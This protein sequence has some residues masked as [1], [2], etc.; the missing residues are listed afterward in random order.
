MATTP[1]IDT[2][3]VDAWLAS[4][5]QVLAHSSPSDSSTR[6]ARSKGGGGDDA[7]SGIALSQSVLPPGLRHVD[8]KEYLAI[9]DE[10]PPGFRALRRYLLQI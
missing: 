5:S 10:L 9:F 1:P 4:I 2:A 6:M 3:A 8:E 7:V